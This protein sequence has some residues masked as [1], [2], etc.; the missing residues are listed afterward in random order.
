MA[1][2]IGV[3][4]LSGI[5]GLSLSG[6]A[7]AANRTSVGHGTGTQTI[8]LKSSGKA[9]PKGTKPINLLTAAVESG[10]AIK[11]DDGVSETTARAALGLVRLDLDTTFPGWTI[12]F[13]GSR[14]G[15]LGLTLV[16]ER[17]VEVYIRSGRSVQGIAHDLAHEL[18]HAID[19]TYNGNEERN[20]YLANRGLDEATPWWTCNS[21]G[22]L[23]V[24]AGDFAETF[25]ILVGPKFKFYSEVGPRP[26]AEQLTA[27]MAGLPAEVGDAV[28]AGTGSPA[29]V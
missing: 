11:L 12:Q 6:V 10:V 13:K 27:I 15:Y 7:G 29:S 9:R 28:R 21:C 24:G 14:A 19:V 20:V 22:D 18:G 26:T 23:Q 3:T 8:R 2:C 16:K 5:N 4:G 1:A 17:R 25:A